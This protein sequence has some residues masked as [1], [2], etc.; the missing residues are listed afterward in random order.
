MMNLLLDTYRD[1]L[2]SMSMGTKNG[3]VAV[4]KPLLLLAVFDGIANG[5]IENNRIDFSNE[6]LRTRFAHLYDDYNDD[7]RGK[8]VAFFIRPFYHLGSS[9]FYHLIWK[10]GVQPPSKSH[11]PSSRYLRDNLD[12]ACFDAELWELLLDSESRAQLREALVE[13]YLR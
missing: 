6:F 11:T 12:Y 3:K 13:R 8:E 7:K 5:K 4:S 9:G 10:S 1:M 2:L